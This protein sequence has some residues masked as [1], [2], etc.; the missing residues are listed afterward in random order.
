MGDT[1]CLNAA[2]LCNWGGQY[3]NAPNPCMDHPVTAQLPEALSKSDTECAWRPAVG[4]VPPSD[5]VT[6]ASTFL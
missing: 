5:C 3:R 6:L 4:P 1:A 2:F